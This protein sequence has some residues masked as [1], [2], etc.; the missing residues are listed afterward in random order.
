MSGWRWAPW[1]IRG[2]A[3][4]LWGKRGMG[5]VAQKL[6]GT[7]PYRVLN[8]T[9]ELLVIVLRLCHHN[10]AAC[11][12][13]RVRHPRD[14]ELP[15]LPHPTHTN[16]VC[17]REAARAI[18]TL[19]IVLP[20]VC[21]DEGME[22]EF[23]N[24]TTAGEQIKIDPELLKTCHSTAKC[25]RLKCLQGPRQV[26]GRWEV[27]LGGQ[28]NG[29]KL[30]VTDDTLAPLKHWADHQYILTGPTWPEGPSSCL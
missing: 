1:S 26:T 24:N 19:H 7:R 11:G 2:L 28:D 15:C 17:P 3:I 23:W 22:T 16:Q 12:H 25:L 30:L 20:V 5:G 10:C 27:S 14:W 6:S 29:C 21:L 8:G 18:C 13:S 9:M 4:G